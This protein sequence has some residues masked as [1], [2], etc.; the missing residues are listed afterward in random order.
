MAALAAAAATQTAEAGLEALGQ[1][2]RV[3]GLGLP[4]E[5]V[6]QVVAAQARQVQ[7]AMP[8]PAALALLF[9]SPGIA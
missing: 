9:P 1:L 6:V 3:T 4:A 2:T 7:A 8:R 5:S